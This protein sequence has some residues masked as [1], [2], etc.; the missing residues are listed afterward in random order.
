LAT[1]FTE[2]LPGNGFINQAI[3]EFSLKTASC[4]FPVIEPSLHWHKRIFVTG[5]LSELQIG[6]SARNIA[7]ARHSGERIITVCNRE[8]IPV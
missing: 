1:G 3:K 5:P 7:G 4:G 2:N 6:P 8:S